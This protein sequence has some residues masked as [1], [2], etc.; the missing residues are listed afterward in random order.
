[1]NLLLSEEGFIQRIVS[2][3]FPPKL[4]GR[5]K[6]LALSAEYHERLSRNGEEVRRGLWHGRVFEPAREKRVIALPGRVA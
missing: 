3:L 1:M 6:N 2:T 4:P 5:I